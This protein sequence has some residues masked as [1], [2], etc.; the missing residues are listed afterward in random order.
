MDLQCIMNCVDLFGT[1]PRN[2]E[3]IEF[4]WWRRGPQ[5]IIKGNMPGLNCLFNTLN[6]RR[7]QPRRPLELAFP[8]KLCN[9][10][11]EGVDSAGSVLIGTY[12]K[13]IT[14]FFQG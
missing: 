4:D 10:S 6:R 5:F 1:K 14:A 8:D 2:A 11:I 7:P 12:L 9:I 3:H 13:G